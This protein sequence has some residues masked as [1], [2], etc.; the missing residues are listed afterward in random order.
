MKRVYSILMMSTVMLVLFAAC[1]GEASKEGKSE[2]LANEGQDTQTDLS[3]PKNLQDAFEQIGKAMGNDPK[4]E[5]TDFRKLKETLPQELSGLKRTNA[6]GERSGALG[7][8]ISKAEGQ[9]ER[10]DGEYGYLKL[11]V[12]DLGTMK[13]AAMFGQAWLMTDFDRESDQGYE[14]TMKY[15]GYP[16][17]EKFDTSGNYSRGEM[18][19]IVADRFLI[20]AESGNLDM[21]KTKSAVDKVIDKVKDFE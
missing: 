2:E 21:D 5:V 20:K 15:K 14:R 18:S 17:Y 16:G 12:T 19:V 10:E 6:S 3:Q 1:G 4:V 11:T 8:K 9:Y 13:N 7:I